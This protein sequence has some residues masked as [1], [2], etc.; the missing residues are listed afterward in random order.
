MLVPLVIVLLVLYTGTIFQ[1][2]TL[3]VE[4]VELLIMKAL[5]QGLLKGRIDEVKL[6]SG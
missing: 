5:S 4:Q 3:P 1:E 2:T 6:Q